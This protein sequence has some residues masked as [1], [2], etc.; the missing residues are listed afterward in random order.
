MLRRLAS[1]RLV[2]PGALCLTLGVLALAAPPRAVDPSAKLPPAVA[3]RV[4]YARDIAPL[5]K[6]ACLSCH[7]P[8]KQKG[9][10]RL[11]S[12]KSALE[13]GSLVPGK[14]AQSTL[15]HLVAGLDSERRMPP[16]GSVLTPKQ[17]G[18]LRAWIDQG[19]PW[20]DEV[21]TVTKHW[22]YQPL[23]KSALPKVK[24]TDWVR[25]PIDAFIL[26]RLEAQQMHPS[27]PAEKRVLLRRLY[28]DLLGLPPT[29][30]DLEAFL[31]DS[32]PDA[33]E[34][35]VD[36]LLA[37]PRYGERWAR[38]WMDLVHYAETHGND[39][40]A[41]R[42]N[43]WHYRDYLIRSFNDDKPYARFVEEQVA[44]DILW[45]EDPQ[46][47]IATG[48]LAAGPW[49]ESSQKD[50]NG[51]TI[52]KKIAQYL[53]RDDMVTTTM[54]T[55][56]STT[57]HCAR[58]HD[59]KFDPISMAE[60]YGL[61]AVFAGID[62][63]NRPFDPDPKIARAR[64]ALLARKAELEKPGPARTTSL[65]SRESQAAVAAWE[66]ALPRVKPW[67]VLEPG[68][69]HV[70]AGTTTT[71]LPDG[72][73]LFGGKR[74]EKDTYTL[75]ARTDHRGITGLRLEVMADA[76]LPHQG[77][78]RQDNG[79]LHL[80]EVRLL[81]APLQGG[82]ARPVVIQRAVADYDQP[83]WTIRMALDGNPQTAWGI[84]PQVGKTHTAVLE[85]KEPISFAG[86]TTLTLHLDQLHGGGHLI[87]RLRIAVTTAPPPL[88]QDPIP[89]AVAAIL[90]LPAEQRSGAQRAELA[91][92]V[93]KKKIESELAQLPPQQM[94]YAAASDF[95]PLNNFT[96]ARGCRPV[97]VLKRGD[98]NKPGELASPGA[99]S[100]VVGLDGSFKLSAPNQEGAR[101]AA[102]ARWLT[103]PRNVL[104]WRSIVNR[105][106]HYHF[107]KGIVATPSDFGKMGGAPTHPELLD[108]LA[109]WFLAN[110]GSLK[111]LHRL[112]VTSNVYRQASL[113]NP[114]YARVD[115]DNRLL[116]R[117]NRSRLDAESIRDAVLQISG[118]LDL[119]MGG[120][121]V[122]QFL[123]SPGIHVTPK[124]EYNKIDVD[125][126]SMYR[127]S[128]YR[129]IFRTLPDPLME[130]L[131]CAD[132][133][134]LTPV[135]HSSV[136]ALHALAM[137]NDRF[138]VRQSEHFATRLTRLSKD[139]REQIRVAYLLALGRPPRPQEIEVLTA[140]A[141]RHGLASVCRLL[142]NTNEF[143]FVP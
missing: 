56:V 134:Q 66:K 1:F 125:H 140:H 129:F 116:W 88:R 51:D 45:P 121:S 127:R 135:R 9:G 14:S 52:D 53:D 131:D 15:I 58:C 137:L 115:A 34:K 73:I 70:S 109:N 101:R 25:T 124:V 61:Q 60:Y 27:A 130:T 48:F 69:V 4:D 76:H 84:Y 13:S 8:A 33:Y 138:L 40:D 142:I 104:T 6:T 136:T 17:I 28:F 29:P 41:P 75:V 49:D 113:H 90:S 32:S 31:K 94:V 72:S 79:N 16:K 62:R 81:A 35:V 117:M 46:A 54:A 133:S 80:S 5:F 30:E 12:K 103:D 24:Q 122:K 20:P 55:F 26:A 83:G 39:Q 98:I 71:R 43:A 68:S 63:A 143:M 2:A 89:D 132:A 36:R 96:P 91:L 100:C 59:H 141:A 7:G 21:R 119:T 128:V 42:D 107:G 87:G 37:S 3:E 67:T 108:W 106:W 44:G 82:T 123:Q 126:P 57:I 19:A 111:K 78:G 97:H 18:I 65:L 139:P 93:L 86:G 92:H 64:H 112:I 85:F 47:L 102:L 22:S 77:P 99:L 50:I 95:T 38:H 74:P 105:V 23:V 114:E 118:K 10:L 110:G 120:P 11:D